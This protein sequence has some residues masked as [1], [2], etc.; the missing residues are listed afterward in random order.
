MF[1]FFNKIKT[2]V[3]TFAKAFAE[4]KVGSVIVKIAKR[5]QSNS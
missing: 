4:T 3:I 1:A 2:K 5:I